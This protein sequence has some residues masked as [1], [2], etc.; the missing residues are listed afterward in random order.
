M[1]KN[2][3][4]IAALFLGAGL[5]AQN[6]EIIEPTNLVTG[7]PTVTEDNTIAVY[8]DVQNNGDA[9]VQVRCRREILV[10][11]DGA[12]ERFC[13]GP[14][15]YDWGTEMSLANGASLVNIPAGEFNSTF[16][17]DYQHQG[18]PGTSLIRYCFFNNQ[19]PSEEVCFDVTYCVD[20]NMQNCAVSVE[21]ISNESTSFQISPNPVANTARIDFNLPNWTPNSK[22]VVYNMV[23]EVMT[24]VAL[25][26]SQGAAQ[27]D[28]SELANGVY[29]YALVVNDQVLST[30]KLV[31]SK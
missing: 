21:Q 28:A 13:W 29:F 3:L 15:C 6:L 5:F 10:L 9:P 8:W 24:E 22:V 23:G 18:N 25:T 14:L 31:V 12:R 19:D 17:G 4:F 16:V 27:I 30:K 11:Q 7:D 26:R 20:E 1:K 2:L